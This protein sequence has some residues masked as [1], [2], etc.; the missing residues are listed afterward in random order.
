MWSMFFGRLKTVLHDP[1]PNTQVHARTSLKTSLKH[2]EDYH[3][4]E[5]FFKYAMNHPY[6]TMHECV[7]AYDEEIEASRV[8]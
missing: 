1:K 7:E 3:D 5:G 6:M 4:A 8:A 2:P